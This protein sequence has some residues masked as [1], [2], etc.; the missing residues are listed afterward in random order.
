MTD[1]PRDETHDSI[2]AATGVFLNPEA[3]AVYLA[4]MGVPDASH[5]QPIEPSQ[6]LPL[7]PSA[8]PAAV[9]EPPAAGEAHQ[10][11]IAQ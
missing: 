3:R 2:D 10:Q 9:V 11:E 8:D 4:D 1:T 6:P 7:A 5:T